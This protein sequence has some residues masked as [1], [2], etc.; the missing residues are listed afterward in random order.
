MRRADLTIAES[1]T[2]DVIGAYV[3]WLGDVVETM[4]ETPPAVLDG[5]ARILRP[6][7][8]RSGHVN[9]VHRCEIC[10][11]REQAG[12]PVEWRPG[13]NVDNLNFSIRAGGIDYYLP[14]MVVHYI[15]AHAYRLPAEVERAIL[16]HNEPAEP[17]T[18]AD[19]GGT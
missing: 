16:A 5:L 13:D 10:R 19:G 3:G 9:G 2:A 12:E 14:R 7:V 6:K 8:G 18:E 17:G 15:T 1:S 11:R 4:G